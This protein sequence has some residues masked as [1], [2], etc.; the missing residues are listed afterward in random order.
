MKGLLIVLIPLFL[1]LGGITANYIYINEVSDQLLTEI[2]AIPAPDQPDCIAKTAALVDAWEKEMDTV[3]LSVSYTITDRISEHAATLH[4]CASCGDRYGFYTSLAL[5]REAIGDM[6][7]LECFSV[8][9]L[10]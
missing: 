8:R 6:R 9:N 10:F 3:S 4:A 2:N 1:L 5:L 7:R